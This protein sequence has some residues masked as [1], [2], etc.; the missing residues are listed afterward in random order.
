M[1]RFFKVLNKVQKYSTFFNKQTK[2]LIISLEKRTEE[3]IKKM[4]NPEY[5]EN[6]LKSDAQLINEEEYNLLLN[7]D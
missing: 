5:R 2:E 1:K 7:S 3:K 6:L 4:R